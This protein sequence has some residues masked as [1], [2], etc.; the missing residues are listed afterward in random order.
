[1]QS[2]TFQCEVVTPLF[3]AGADGATPEF[4]APSIKGAMRFWWRAIS[5]HLRLAELKEKEGLIFGDT[6]SRSL[7]TLRVEDVRVQKGKKKPTPH[8]SF[9]QECILEG[10]T[11]KVSLAVPVETTDWNLEKCKALFELTCLLGDF[12]KRARR[13][14]GSIDITACSDANW[15]K[16]ATTLGH[17][18]ALLKYFSPH[19]TI[20]RDK[21]KNIYSGGMDYYPW[22]SYIQIGEPNEGLLRKISDTAHALHSQNRNV[23]EASLGHATYGRFASPIYVSVVKGSLKPVITTLNTIPDRDSRDTSLRLQDD[24]K[25]RIL[26]S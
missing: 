20:D 23:Y 6:N 19:Y 16:Q 24:F 22:I 1:M 17:L 2:I 15:K 14:M 10:S 18:D 5:G 3:M 7:F 12:G 8:R 11:F 13:G 26:N 25:K 9:E 4:R 21:L